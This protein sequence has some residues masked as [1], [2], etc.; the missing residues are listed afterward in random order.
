MLFT[1]VNKVWLSTRQFP[2][3]PTAHVNCERASFHAPQLLSFN[4]ERATFHTT[5][6]LNVNPS[7]P[8]ITKYKTQRA[9]A[10]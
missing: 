3:T 6:L 4:C 7:R 1:P 8:P 10:N 9:G 2:R 5:Q